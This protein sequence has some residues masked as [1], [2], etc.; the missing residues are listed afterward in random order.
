MSKNL[1]R[2]D[3]Q[4]RTAKPSKVFQDL[5]GTLLEDLTVDDYNKLIGNIPMEQENVGVIADL[6]TVMRF[7]EKPKGLQLVKVEQS[8]LVNSSSLVTLLEIPAG[9]TYDIQVV[10]AIATTGTSTMSYVL[11]AVDFSG[12][13][14]LLKN[15]DY[16]GTDGVAIDFS[17]QGDFLLSGLS[18]QS[19]FL[20][21]K[22]A[23]GSGSVGGHNVFYR[24]VN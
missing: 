9:K 7:Q 2:S 8:G 13:Q 6:A 20:K 12:L 16:D 11:D 10:C 1:T 17:T 5:S 15:V 23:S 14:Y 21:V 24:E 4:K 18:D 3:G 22:R 19:T